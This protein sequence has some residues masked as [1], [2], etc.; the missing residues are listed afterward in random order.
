MRMHWRVAVG[1]ALVSAGVF[2][3]LKQPAEIDP[4]P[5]AQVIQTVTLDADSYKLV[6]NGHV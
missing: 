4:L 5:D 2:W 6:D 3:R 1:V